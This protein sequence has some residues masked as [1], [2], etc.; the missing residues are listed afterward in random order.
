MLINNDLIDAAV[1]AENI[2]YKM[3]RELTE[4]NMAGTDS[5]PYRDGKRKAEVGEYAL[6]IN[7]LYIL[8]KRPKVS[9]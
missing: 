2:E 1:E 3:T 6:S 4:K 9:T 7:Y 5:F 8:Q